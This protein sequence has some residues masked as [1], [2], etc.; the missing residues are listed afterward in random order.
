MKADSF[1]ARE[2]MRFKATHDALTSL[3]NRGAIMEL[4]GREIS[5]SRRERVP[6]AILRCDVDHF[7]DINDTYGH[8]IG[9]EVLQEAARRLLLSV[10]SYDYVRRYGGEEL[11]IILSN[12][13]PVSAARRAEEIRKSLSDTPVQTSIGPLLVTVSMGVHQTQNWGVR[14]VEKLSHEVDSAM[15]AAAKAEGRNRISLT[16]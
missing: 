10:R 6:A 16:N 1:E 7:K 4:L 11:L 14:T 12:C 15:Y 13:D 9:D 8:L 5:R 2:N 3:F